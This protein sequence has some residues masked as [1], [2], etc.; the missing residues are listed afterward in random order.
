MPS[1]VLLTFSLVLFSIGIARPQSQVVTCATLAVN[2][3]LHAEGITEVVGDI[4][5]SCSGGNPGTTMSLNLTVFLNVGVTNRVSAAGSTDVLLTVDSG[6]GPTPASVPAV[7]QGS[8]GVSFNGFSFTVPPSGQVNLRVSN[9]RGNASQR[10]AGFQQPIQASMTLTGLPLV[11]SLNPVGV[12]IPSAGLLA[13]YASTGIRCVGSAL[14]STISFSSLFQ[15]GTRFA[16]TRVTEGFAT[17]FQTKAATSDTGIRILARYSGFPSEARLFVPTVVAGSDAAQPTAAGDLGGTPSA[18][19]YVP[20]S[21]S[22]LLALVNGTDANGAGGTPAFSPGAPGSGTVAFDAVSEVRLTNGSGVAVYEVV[23][24]NPNVRESAQFPTF[25]GLPPIT[26]GSTPVAQEQVSFAP[27]STIF[28]ATATDPVPRFVGNAPPSDCPSLADCNAGYF[29]ALSVF[30]SQPLQ[31]TAIAGSALQTKT[32]QV[33]N[34]G[35]GVL[36]WTAS[37]LNANGAN[38]ITVYPASGVNGGTVL[39]NVFPQ[40]IGPGVYN[41]TLLIE[42]GPQAGSQ[43]LPITLTVTAFPPPS[44]MPTPTPTP[45]PPAPT[46]SSVVLQSLTNAARPDSTDVSP[47]SLGVVKGSHLKGTN[48][49]VTFDGAP[50]TMVSGDDTSVTVQVPPA[51]TPGAASQLQVTVDGNK[52]APLAVS[53]SDLAPAIFANGILNEDNSINSP[54][55][56]ATVGTPLQIFSTGLI[57]AV[58]VPIVVKLHDRRLTPVFAGPAPGVGVNQVNVIIP[59]DLPAMTTQLSVCGYGMMNPTQPICSQ[60]T[61]V[62]LQQPQQ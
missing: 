21:G 13:S 33:N 59:D 50:A 2:P 20:G 37:I 46:P 7:L 40:N 34:K 9:L 11:A 32:V 35:G 4:L 23:D 41:A 3:P 5:I 10:G 15:F 56:A 24:A 18:G 25:I 54:G 49:A 42:G 6:S 58:L 39:V 61:D 29:P 17:S 1:R 14:P 45:Q 8:N 52:S 47:G 38:W 27:V 36:S 51:L 55:N 43:T 28:N 30:A 53:I 48:V 12:G 26:D 22:L 57:P 16:S 31:F 62:T 19:A 44:P 60:P